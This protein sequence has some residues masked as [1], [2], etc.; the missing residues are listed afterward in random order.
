VYACNIW[1]V[2]S[3]KDQIIGAYGLPTLEFLTAAMLFWLEI[4]YGYMLKAY[5]EN[6]ETYGKF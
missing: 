1:E 5:L 6:S 4:S 3:D 2:G